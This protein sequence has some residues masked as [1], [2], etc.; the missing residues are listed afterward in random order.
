MRNTLCILALFVFSNIAIANMAPTYY[1]TDS[2]GNN[3]ISLMP[4]D[5][6][7][8]SIWHYIL[9]PSFDLKI[10]AVGSGTLGQPI[11]TAVGRNS[12]YDSVGLD[13]TNWVIYSAADSGTYIDTGIEKPLA[14]INFQFNG[15][16][17]VTLNLYQFINSIWDTYA[18]YGMTIHQ[19]PEPI[20]LVF[21]GLGGLLLR[22]RK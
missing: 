14:T 15:P 12:E 1:I 19:I 22:R 11:I 17:D 5:T 6:I 20:T 10:E 4:S 7:E 9:I 3:E 13:E 2:S 21:L 8:L 16:G 18:S